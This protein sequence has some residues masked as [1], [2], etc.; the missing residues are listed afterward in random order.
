MEELFL[1]LV[2]LPPRSQ[3]LLGNARPR[4]SAS[5][6]QRTCQVLRFCR[7]VGATKQSFEAVRSQAE[8]GNEARGKR[9]DARCPTQPDLLDQQYRAFADE[10]DPVTQT[11]QA[12][13]RPVRLERR[14]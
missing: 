10:A 6:G 2:P 12:G 1:P 8:L 13:N 3:A 14:R 5:R 4:S 11:A 7:D 9:R